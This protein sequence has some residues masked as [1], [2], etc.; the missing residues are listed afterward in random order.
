MRR[1]DSV[2]LAAYRNALAYRQVLDAE[3]RER[4]RI[5]EGLHDDIVQALTASLI[6]MDRLTARLS[7]P[8]ERAIFQSLRSISS[9]R[10]TESGG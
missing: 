4:A 10:P 9:T 2:Y 7:D 8:S 3:R 5:A 6:Q 1:L